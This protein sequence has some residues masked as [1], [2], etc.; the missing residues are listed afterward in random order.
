ML[1][2]WLAGMEIFRPRMAV[3]VSSAAVCV[4]TITLPIRCDIPAQTLKSH[5]IFMKIVFMREEREAGWLDPQGGRSNNVP[6]LRPDG[7]VA[8]LWRITVQG[9]EEEEERRKRG[10]AREA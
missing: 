6:Q 3:L 9:E 1:S 4:H 7:Q 2:L 8:T 5:C 10:E